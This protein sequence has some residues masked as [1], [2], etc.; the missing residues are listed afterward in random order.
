MTSLPWL[1]PEANNN[2]SCMKGIIFMD[3]GCDLT[4]LLPKSEQSQL[5]PCSGQLWAENEYTTSF[6]QYDYGT[7][8]FR[9]DHG[10]WTFGSAEIGDACNNPSGMFCQSSESIARGDGPCDTGA[11]YIGQGGKCGQGSGFDME[12]A[13]WD[14]WNRVTGKYHYGVFRIVDES[15]QKTRWWNPYLNSVL[16]TTCKKV[17]HPG[18]HCRHSQWAKTGQIGACDPQPQL[19]EG[20]LCG[21][22]PRF[23]NGPMMP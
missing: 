11:Y 15:G 20:D 16:S 6:L 10:T 12:K 19:S 14:G 9:V 22:P 4:H 18:Q 17:W 1:K 5:K 21:G 2:P 3:Q 7:R 8:C 23:A 13:S